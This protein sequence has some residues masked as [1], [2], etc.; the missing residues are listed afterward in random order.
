MAITARTILLVEDNPDDEE[1]TLRALARNKIGNKVVVVRDGQEALEWLD[2]TGAHADRDANDVPALILLDL[3]LP[4]VDGLEVLRHVRHTPRTAIVPVVI[5][6]SSKEDRDRA[7][8]YY[9]GANSY[10][11]KPVD[12]TSFVDAVRQLGLYWLVLNEPPPNPS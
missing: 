12:F 10:V 11:Q 7:E 2:G 4:K 8:G 1:L 5:L 3:K 9:G 6:T